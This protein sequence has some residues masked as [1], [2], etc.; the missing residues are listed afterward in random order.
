MRSP[1]PDQ[2]HRH[3]HQQAGQVRIGIS[4][5]RYEP[6]RGVFY[7]DELPQ[8]RELTFASRALPSIE[9]NGTFYALQK[10]SSFEAWFND[11]PDDFV[12][13]VKATR[14]VTHIR[15]LKDVAQPI[16]NFLASGVLRLRHKLGPILWPFRR[17]LRPGQHGLHLIGRQGLV[18]AQ[19]EARPRERV[20]GL[21]TARA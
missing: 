20:Q 15:R 5:W 6:W 7:P 2:P 16:A 18:I 10:P 3:L 1:S 12:F 11:T 13:S 19:L 4:G 8:R 21:A 9:I 14:Y 17:G